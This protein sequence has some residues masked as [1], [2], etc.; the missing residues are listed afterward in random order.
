MVDEQIQ[1]PVQSQPV[2]QPVPQQPIVYQQTIQSLPETPKKS[3][4]W[5]WW[6]VGVIVL[7]MLGIGA[8]ILFSSGS[9][10]PQ[11]PSLPE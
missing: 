10:I 1:Q 5:I 2:S 3:R 9:S 6:L 7:V 8:W 11:P 4:A